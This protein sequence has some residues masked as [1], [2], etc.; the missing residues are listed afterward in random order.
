MQTISEINSYIKDTFGL[1]FVDEEISDIIKLNSG[2]FI[3]NHDEQ[4]EYLDLNDYL[5]V[6]L[7]L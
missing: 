1:R 2:I 7:V 6:A 5:T 4:F 3:V